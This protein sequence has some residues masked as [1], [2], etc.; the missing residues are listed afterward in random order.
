M[1]QVETEIR[2]DPVS[3]CFRGFRGGIVGKSVEQ[4]I[5]GSVFQIFFDIVNGIDQ[6]DPFPQMPAD[7]TGGFYKKLRIC[8]FF[9]WEL[10]LYG[11]SICF[12][13]RPDTFLK[14]DFHDLGKGVC[15]LI[16]TVAFCLLQG[17][18][19]S[20]VFFDPFA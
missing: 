2:L 15:R 10:R 16:D 1:E 7:L 5:I 9:R 18:K 13:Q 11:Y 4:G 14:N 17:S 12:I 19:F 8:M 3:E 6:I 20:Q